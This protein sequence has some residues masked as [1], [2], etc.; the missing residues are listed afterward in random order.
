MTRRSQ[1][2]RPSSARNA[3]RHF[4][5]DPHEKAP[6]RVASRTKAG[7]VLEIL[8]IG[9][10]PAGLFFSALMAKADRGHRITLVERLPADAPPG[11]GVVFS[12]GALASLS[13]S[14]RETY[15]AIQATLVRWDAI[16][17]CRDD[18]I[19]RAN[20]HGFS[21]L[22]RERLLQILRDRCLALGV[23][24]EFG[25]QV[26]DVE[27]IR[28]DYD[29]VV[30]CDGAASATRAR[31]AEVFNPTLVNGACRYLWLGT[32]RRLDAFTFGFAE[33]EHGCFQ[34]H[35]YPFD[36]STSAFIAECHADVLTRSALEHAPITM[37]IEYLARV[38]AGVLDGA[39]LLGGGAWRAFV[40][41][42]NARWHHEN[43]VL[44]G[45]AAHTAHFSIGSGTRLALD[46]AA[47]LAVALNGSHRQDDALRAYE[48]TR[49]PVVEKTQRAA[50]RSAAWFA[51]VDRHI[52]LPL[53]LLSYELLARSGKLSLEDIAK[54]DPLFARQVQAALAISVADAAARVEPSGTEV[55][56]PVATW[57]GVEAH[58][59]R[60]P[61][62][63]V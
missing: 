21:G 52:G 36:A 53:P 42:S 48:A 15:D 39:S 59:Q 63:Q 10:G 37:S 45:D 30:A 9:G 44:L 46:D 17:I 31:Y 41:V 60:K 29:L 49:R 38:F 18:E 58:G 25:R 11:W 51:E 34:T 55:A 13:D 33:T 28:A 47:A 40:T 32:Q 20:G 23:R 16:D 26:T 57:D 50:A 35:A 8:C 3:R 14:D 5:I 24:F 12:D 7:A 4:D 27:P 1:L 43:V 62:V 6:S 19:V 22:R 2:R 56:F 54:R 61:R